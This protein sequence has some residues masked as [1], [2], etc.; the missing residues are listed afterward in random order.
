MKYAFLLFYI[1]K[2]KIYT[3]VT[4]NAFQAYENSPSCDIYVKGEWLSLYLPLEGLE[5]EVE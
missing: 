1:L 5:L 2:I 4:R 3:I